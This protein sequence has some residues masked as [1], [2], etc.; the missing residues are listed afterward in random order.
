MDVCFIQSA[1][2]VTTTLPQVRL[3][4]LGEISTEWSNWE[5]GM[6][7]FPS[8]PWTDGSRNVGEKH[9]SHL[10]NVIDRFQLHGLRCSKS[11]LQFL[12]V[13]NSCWVR[14]SNLK[15]RVLKLSK[16]MHRNSEVPD[17][18]FLFYL[19]FLSI[20]FT[21]AGCCSWTAISASITCSHTHVSV[22]FE[23]LHVI[24]WASLVAQLIIWLQCGRPG[25]D[26]WV[27]R[28]PGKG[29]GYLLQCSGL[30]NSMG[31][32]RVRLSSFIHAINIRHLA[33]GLPLSFFL[34]LVV[35]CCI[36]FC[37]TA[38]PVNQIYPSVP[39][40]LALLSLSRQSSE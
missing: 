11:F 10:R 32:Q 31:S 24:N 28:L 14:S 18:K 34:F 25:F 19:P 20:S 8:L 40:P 26:P 27:G 29:K 23:S 4:N 2:R 15:E 5:G 38:K 35:Q 16:S 1:T 3:W 39:H 13:L 9:F 37:H 30:E 22:K 33:N 17:M 36:S 7:C 6:M 21:L 12:F